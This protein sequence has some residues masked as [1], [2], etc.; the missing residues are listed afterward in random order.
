MPSLRRSLGLVRAIFNKI[1]TM[2]SIALCYPLPCYYGVCTERN[3]AGSAED[4]LKYGTRAQEDRA[5]TTPARSFA[6]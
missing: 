5:Y 3:D 4:K 2:N 6:D 1:W